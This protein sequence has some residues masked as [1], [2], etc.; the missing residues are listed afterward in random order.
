MVIKHTPLL[1][2]HYFI[3]ACSLLSLAIVWGMIFDERWP[4][5]QLGYC[6][7]VKLAI[8]RA[9]AASVW[10]TLD[11]QILYRHARWLSLQIS[12]MCPRTSMLM[13]IHMPKYLRS[14]L[15]SIS[16]YPLLGTYS[17]SIYC[18]KCMRL[19]AR[20]FTVCKVF[21]KKITIQTNEQLRLLL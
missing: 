10:Q 12:H 4:Y 21:T 5:H 1:G 19:L 11:G 15:C 8:C 17:L 18:Y 6:E 3:S 2:A 14:W 7:T 13:I 9:M 20:Y 16:T